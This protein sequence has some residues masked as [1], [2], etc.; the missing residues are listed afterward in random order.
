MR[1]INTCPERAIETSH[2]YLI[3]ILCLLNMGIM[4][5][6]WQGVGRFISV[7]EDD[8]WAQG[9]VTLTGWVLTFVVMVLSYRVFHYLLRIP[10]I[11][12]FFYFTSLTRF[13]F[14]RRYRAPKAC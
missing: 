1:C 11:R 14:W 5:W 13:R 4:T 9:A 6:F 12:R 2:V 7:P 3:G 8:G 10:V